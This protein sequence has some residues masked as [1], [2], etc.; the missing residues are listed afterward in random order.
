MNS[1]SACAGLWLLLACNV[2]DAQSGTPVGTRDGDALFVMPESMERTAEGLR[3]F[4]RVD[5][6]NPITHRPSGRTY[7]STRM[8]RTVRCGPRTM[9]VDW[10]GLYAEPGAKGE[11]IGVFS[12]PGA[13]Y[14][15][16]PVAPGSEDDLLLKFV[17]GQQPKP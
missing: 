6:S 10:W 17:C 2:A 12:P 9:A 5:H 8:Q 16:A 11:L 14:H 13:A 3:F 7:R 4:A 1:C 15:F